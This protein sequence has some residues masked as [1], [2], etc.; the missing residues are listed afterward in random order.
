[1]RIHRD[2]RGQTIILVA[3]SL[4][5]LLGFV[6]I[7]TDVGALFKDK[8]T[9]Q[10]AADAAAIAGAL[11][12]NYGNI[13]PAGK[14]AAA[15]NGYTN[16]S[17][18]VTV[19]VVTRPTW[20]ASNYH[21][22]TGYVEATITKTESTIFLALFGHPSVTVTARAVATNQAPGAGCLYTVG[23][24]GI[25]FRNNGD[26]GCEASSCGLVVESSDPDAWLSMALRHGQ[27]RLSRHR[28]RRQ[29]ER[30]PT[31]PQ[32]PPRHWDRP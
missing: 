27:L 14:A 32:R 31:I 29:F 8:R 1:M 13:L 3:L 11:N 30:Q 22:K 10:T 20:P 23:T 9:M 15:S 28:G 24:T 16:G 26:S 6:G 12:L 5:L 25:G 2:E 17:N 4:P 21:G 7:A 18:G 19:N